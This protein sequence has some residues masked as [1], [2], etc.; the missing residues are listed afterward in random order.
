MPEL[1][2]IVIL[3]DANSHYIFV[4]ESKYFKEVLEEIDRQNSRDLYHI[5]QCWYQ[6]LYAKCKMN[7]AP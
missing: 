5:V 7:T 6:T 1:G 2:E 4:K 3:V